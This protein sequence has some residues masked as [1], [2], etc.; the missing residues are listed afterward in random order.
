MVEWRTGGWSASLQ[1][2]QWRNR[3]GGVA[4]GRVDRES[5]DSPVEE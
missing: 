3:H 5:P 2:R 4:D 1:T